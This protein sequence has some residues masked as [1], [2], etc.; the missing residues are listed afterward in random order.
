MGAQG[1][2]AGTQPV[3]A[4]TMFHNRIAP[5][6]AVHMSGRLVLPLQQVDEHLIEIAADRI[7]LADTQIV[8]LLC[9][10]LPVEGVPRPCPDQG[11]CGLRPGVE[12]LVIE[13]PIAF[14]G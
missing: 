14:P 11:R 9:Q 6:M 7:V 2:R 10:G 4:V 12:I 3:D 1:G 13:S 8:H 5:A